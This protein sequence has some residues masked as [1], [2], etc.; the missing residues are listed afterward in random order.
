MTG[1]AGVAHFARRCQPRPGPAAPRSAR[2]AP[3]ARRSRSPA[4]P[5]S[6]PARAPSRAP[7]ANVAPDGLVALVADRRFDLAPRLG[8]DGREAGPD[9]AA[10]GRHDLDRDRPRRRARGRAGQRDDRDERPDPPRQ[11]ARLA[12]RSRPKDPNGD[13]PQGHQDFVGL[14]PGRRALRDAGRRPPVGRRHRRRPHRPV[15]RGARSRSRSIGRSSPPRRSGSAPDRLVI[16]TGDAASPAGDRSWTRRPASCPMGRSAPASW[17][18]RRTATGSRR[19]T[20]RAIR[21]SSATRPAG[22]PATASSIASIAPPSGST[23]AIAFALD[24][25]GQRFVV[26]WQAKDGSVTLAVYDGRSDWR[27]VSKPAIG[28]A[29]GAVVAW[30]R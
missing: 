2:A 3:C 17:P 14:G 23:T 30:R 19:W 27:R 26:A 8:R 24:A 16:V 21:S 25:V 29:K 18:R 13:A 1:A 11:D 5:R 28:A 7:P 9:Q 12:D 10:E 4:W 15:G 22:S 20:R 6:R